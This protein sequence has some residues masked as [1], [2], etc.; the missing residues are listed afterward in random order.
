MNHRLIPSSKSLVA[1]LLIMLTIPVFCLPTSASV[2][3]KAEGN[4]GSSLDSLQTCMHQSDAS[5]NIVYIVDRSASMVDSDPSVARSPMVESTL[6]ILYQAGA[7]LATGRVNYAYVSFG[8]R[9]KDETGW[10]A[11]TE[12]N[13][14][15]ELSRVRTLS[16][17]ADA[18][19]TDWKAGLETARDLVNA[20]IQQSP[21]S[22]FVA[23]WLTDGQI[24]EN[25]EQTGYVSK[26]GDAYKAIC[27]SSGVINWFRDPKN[28]VSLLGALLSKNE[29][30]LIEGNATGEALSD[31]E[32]SVLLFE[33]VVTGHSAIKIPDEVVSQFGL[34]E[35]NFE[36][37]IYTCGDVLNDSQVGSM[38]KSGD[39]ADLSWNFVE[40]VAAA[41]GLQKVE[42]N[43]SSVE[44]PNAI[45]KI[46]IYAK[47]SAS[48]TLTLTDQNGN[49]V[50]DLESACTQ[51][52]AIDKG[53]YSVFDVDVPN[54]TNPGSW[55]ISI[56]PAPDEFKVYVGLNGKF[57]DVV[58]QPDY[59]PSAS[60]SAYV[61]GT[62]ITS[63]F[64]V[65]DKNGQDLSAELGDVT[66][67]LDSPS[68]PDGGE[69]CITGSQA[70]FPA[71]SVSESDKKLAAHAVISLPN[72]QPFNIYTSES[73]VV[74]KGPQFAKIL[75]N[76]SS[77]CVLSPIPNKS[78]KSVT[79]LNIEGG[80]KGTSVVKVV[81]FRAED[82]PERAKSYTASSDEVQ[83]LENTDSVKIE[84]TLSNP[85][86]KSKKKDIKGTLVYT[87]SNGDQGPI[88][89]EA[90]VTFSISQDKDWTALII[91]YLIAL[92]AGVGLPY[93]LLLLQARRA[94]VFVDEEFKF[95]TVPVVISKSGQLFSQVSAP[96]IDSAEQND[97]DVDDANSA[98]SIFVTPD[99]SLLSRL[100]GIEK[101]SKSIEIGAAKVSIKP[102]RFD[103]FAPIQVH[104]SIPNSVITS[105]FGD[106][107]N[108]LAVGQTT[109]DQSVD[110]L[111]FIY[112][113]TNILEPDSRPTF[114]DSD[115]SD[116]D[117]MSDGSSMKMESELRPLETE[118]SGSLVIVLAGTKNYTKALEKL[119]E[120]LRIKNFEF[121]NASLANLRKQRIDDLLAAEAKN[122]VASKS[123]KET[124]SGTPDS[125]ETAGQP[126][127]SPFDDEFDDWTFTSSSTDTKPN[128]FNDDEF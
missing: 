84:V 50:C 9:A 32:K 24:D 11:L 28:N 19:G 114:N 102:V 61:D 126:T 127:S 105:N 57:R 86:A 59:V 3:V 44:I 30:D 31:F 122:Q 54:G 97:A 110:G 121:V 15:S 91:G 96:S 63:T 73:I 85:N 111:V 60:N 40:L 21:N 18:D 39:A 36:N 69:N 34:S 43:N 74:N 78:G 103:A 100:M 113:S 117:F 92:A 76:E 104:L 55:K 4:N 53:T 62:R 95:L 124:T 47:G 48:R 70:T 37:G 33:P 71:F 87:V 106:N 52:G 112:E 115:Y 118:F 109:A 80:N 98:R 23:L 128:Q 51:S 14:A 10:V 22:C 82:I 45:G 68:L 72:L 81:G 123:S 35:S 56:E 120:S 125:S 8:T 89:V 119:S 49:N 65:V 99:R 107:A 77:P 46:Q 17:A 108:V 7:H 116:D 16:R 83:V 75:C 38:E 20:K 64:S 6:R 12:K 79:E 26:T 67:C 93:L 42:P 66:I 13:L 29:K 88:T 27:D 2:N 94:A 101:G 90:P 58:L 25:F 41:T 5:L 1:A